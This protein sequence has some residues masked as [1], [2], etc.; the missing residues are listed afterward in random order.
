[1]TVDYTKI[2]TNALSALV[3]TVFIGAAAIVWKQATSIDQKIEEA[4][5]SIR[6]QQVKLEATQT[7][8]VDEIAE[9]KNRIK[10]LESQAMSV[11]KV[12][13]ETDR[14]RDRVKYEIDRPF[15]L[16]EFKNQTSP[17]TYKKEEI[18]RIKG[19]IDIRQQQMLPRMG[20]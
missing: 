2:V 5:G 11:T 3:A 18:N 6:G 15:I 4:K 20:D 7:T 19:E 10:T 16:K 13:S 14:T 12:L 8:V 1:M 9:L 17:E